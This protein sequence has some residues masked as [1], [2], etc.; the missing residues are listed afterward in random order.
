MKNTGNEKIMRK[1]V[2]YLPFKK[3]HCIPG[4]HFNIGSTLFQRCGSTLKKHWS[5][6]ENETKSDVG[7]SMLY[8]VDTKSMSDVETTLNQCCT[9]SIKPVFNVAQRGFNVLCGIIWTLFQRGLK[10]S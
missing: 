10:V 7:I 8:Y 1:S 3:K 6:F 4:Q 5:G 9:T 2:F